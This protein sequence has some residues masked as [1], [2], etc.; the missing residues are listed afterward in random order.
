[1][2]RLLKNASLVIVPVTAPGAGVSRWAM[3]AV[4]YGVPTVTNPAGVRGINCATYGT[5]AS[6]ACKLMHVVTTWETAALISTIKK[7]RL[8]LSQQPQQA[9]AKSSAGLVGLEASRRAWLYTEDFFK[10]FVSSKA[11]LAAPLVQTYEFLG[12]LKVNVKKASPILTDRAP[13]HVKAVN[14]IGDG[15]KWK[16]ALT[17]TMKM[18]V[19][20]EAIECED[21]DCISKVMSAIADSTAKIPK[22][23][24][25][26]V[27]KDILAYL[28]KSKI[29]KKKSRF[30]Y[31][32]A[33]GVDVKRATPILTG[34]EAVHLKANRTSWKAELTKTMS[35]LVEG[36]AINCDNADCF[37]KVMLAITEAGFT[38]ASMPKLDFTQAAIELVMER[39]KA[40]REAKEKELEKEKEKEAKDAKDKDSGKDKKK[41]KREK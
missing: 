32:G 31:L 34:R 40:E 5:N 18:L 20:S 12:Q 15:F 39:E 37:A 6:G 38:T 2:D 23:D 25:T 41:K 14:P 27:A 4:R 17:K 8:S 33:L 30:D 1:V 10:I 29:N 11:N 21:A 26:E 36:K 9:P 19:D 7:A 22:L 16:V 28:S 13:S 24:Y 35:L 3:Q